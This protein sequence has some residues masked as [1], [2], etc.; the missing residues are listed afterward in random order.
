MDEELVRIYNTLSQLEVRGT[1]VLILAD[2]LR[3]LREHIERSNEEQ[4]KEQEK[5]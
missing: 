5:D 1:N 3:A 2:C 4:Q